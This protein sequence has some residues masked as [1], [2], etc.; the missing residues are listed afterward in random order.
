MA[1]LVDGTRL[2]RHSGH[3]SGAGTRAPAST[4]GRLAVARRRQSAGKGVHGA[5]VHAAVSSSA[6]GAPPSVRSCLA[7]PCCPYGRLPPPADQNPDGQ[8]L[9][10][11]FGLAA[12][13]SHLKHV[14]CNKRG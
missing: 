6:D 2:L 10:A 7:E 12:A 14:L 9:M 11:K 1:Q 4:G 8:T 3:T 5:S 13:S